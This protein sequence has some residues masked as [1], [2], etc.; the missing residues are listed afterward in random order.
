MTDMNFPNPLA[1]DPDDVILA[2][3][4]AHSL[5]EG[6]DVGEAARWLRKA[7]SA[8]EEAGNDRRAFD[9]AKAASDVEAGPAPTPASAFPAPAASGEATYTQAIRVAVKRSLRDGDLFVAR[10]LDNQPVPTGSHEA[11]LV[12]T[13]P[14]LDL[15]DPSAN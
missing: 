1:D 7:A 5:W 9:L 8:A 12:L 15:F 13:N 2:L 11:F 14:N 4:S 3:K 10:L 6:G